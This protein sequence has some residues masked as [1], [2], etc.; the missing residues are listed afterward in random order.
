MYNVELQIEVPTT[1]IIMNNND[2]RTNEQIQ[3]QELLQ[4]EDEPEQF[5]VDQNIEEAQAKNK[6][7][8]KH[9][10]FRRNFVSLY[11]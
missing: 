11:N 4:A 8:H 6:K 9:N 3:Q 7:N 1:D 2:D 10:Q 5:N